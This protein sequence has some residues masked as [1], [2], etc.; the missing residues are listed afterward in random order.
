M[1]YIKS[2]CTLAYMYI[3]YV[4]DGLHIISRGLCTLD[5]INTVL[6]ALICKP[7]LAENGTSI[8]HVL[9]GNM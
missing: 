5:H 4:N 8:M 3:N 2:T 9:W 6:Y 7:F 1:P